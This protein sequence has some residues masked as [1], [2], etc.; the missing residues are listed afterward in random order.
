MFH[1][2][3][4]HPQNQA[5]SPLL[6]DQECQCGT[7]L[8]P[9]VLK[10]YQWNAL[11]LIYLLLSGHSVMSD[12]LWPHGLQ[13]T[14]CVYIYY[15]HYI[16]FIYIYIYIIYIIYI[17]LYILKPNKCTFPWASVLIS[18]SSPHFL[19]WAHSLGTPQCGPLVWHTDSF[20]RTCEDNKLCF[21]LPFLCP[22]LWLH[23][24]NYVMKEY[25]TASQ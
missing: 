12:S 10:I 20:S 21:P 2:L 7:W 15:I 8:S 6:G 14:G 5:M 9:N 13:H 11:L 24:T 3:P 23:L 25:R 19:G 22:L 1:L 16:Y 17:Y 18:T 4:Q